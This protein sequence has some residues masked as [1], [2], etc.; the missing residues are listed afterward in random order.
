MGGPKR[1]G[2]LDPH[3]RTLLLR[4]P[5]CSISSPLAFGQWT[6][7]GRWG[8]A[9]T[10]RELP[11][12]PAA[13]PHS[14]TRW[15]AVAVLGTRICVRVS[16]SRRLE[17]LWAWRGAHSVSSIFFRSFGSEPPPPFGAPFPPLWGLC[18]ALL[19]NYKPYRTF[20][21]LWFR[22]HRALF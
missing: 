11:S 16:L 13:S 10:W 6:R 22:A 7:P 1:W 14:G 3:G 21:G 12:G 8:D 4:V 20:S 2:A 15:V 18:F 9:N 5:P 17:G 19:L